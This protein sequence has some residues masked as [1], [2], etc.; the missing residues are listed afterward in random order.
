MHPAKETNKQMIAKGDYCLRV[1][2]VIIVNLK[3]TVYY[4]TN[5]KLQFS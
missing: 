5:A 2:T 1:F 4:S 3:I